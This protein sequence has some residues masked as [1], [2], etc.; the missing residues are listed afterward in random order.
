MFIKCRP[1][2]CDRLLGQEYSYKEEKFMEGKTNDQFY[3]SYSTRNKYEF[4]E[5]IPI[6]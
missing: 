5:L 6:S 2:I 3:D 1:Q 4:N